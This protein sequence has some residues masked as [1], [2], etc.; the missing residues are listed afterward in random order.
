MPDHIVL[1]CTFMARATP[2]YL[3]YFLTLWKFNAGVL[4]H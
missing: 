4:M 3:F 1:I 2:F